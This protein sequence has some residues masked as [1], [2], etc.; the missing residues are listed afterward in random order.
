MVTLPGVMRISIGYGWPIIAGMPGGKQLAVSFS[1]ARG[2]GVLAF[3]AY[4]GVRDGAAGTAPRPA[5][6]GAVPR[7]APL[8]PGAVSQ[9]PLK[10]GSL[11]IADQSAAVG[12][13]RTGFWPA[14]NGANTN[15]A[16]RYLNKVG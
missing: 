2:C 5:A 6:P 13:F 15:E 11:A 8:P 10:S 3:A 1:S 7:P 16:A 4:A 9:T 12:A 14:A